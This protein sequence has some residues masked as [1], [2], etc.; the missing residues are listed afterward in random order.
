M[1]KIVETFVLLPPSENP[2]P[3][4]AFGLDFLGPSCLTW[5]SPQ[6]FSIFI[7]PMLKGLDKTL[8]ES[9]GCN[10]GTIG[11]RTFSRILAHDHRRNFR[12][13]EGYAYPNFLKWGTLPLTLGSAHKH[14]TRRNLVRGVR[15]WA[16]PHCLKWVLYVPLALGS[17]HNHTLW[18]SASLSCA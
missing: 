1:L 15:V 7:S 5:Q 10:V 14:N 17:A 13:Y 4:W 16:Y 8:H 3:L 11:Q 9:H 12:G 18:C 6:Q 2:T